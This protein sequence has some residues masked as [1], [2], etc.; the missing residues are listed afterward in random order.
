[1]DKAPK[2]GETFGYLRR[3]DACNAYHGYLFMCRH[4]DDVIKRRV[5]KEAKAFKK[6]IKKKE[7]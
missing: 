1:M 7:R 6:E 3:C 4:Y 2:N 5:E